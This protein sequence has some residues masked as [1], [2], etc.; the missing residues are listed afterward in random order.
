MD[1]TPRLSTSECKPS[2]GPDLFIY[3]LDF[4]SENHA[5]EEVTV[6]IGGSEC[7]D[8]EIVNH[9]MIKCR[10]PTG[11]GE[12]LPVHLTLALKPQVR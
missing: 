12:D 9:W 1:S 4:G 2:G 11:T 6:M 8:A 10:L 3:G 7:E 5:V